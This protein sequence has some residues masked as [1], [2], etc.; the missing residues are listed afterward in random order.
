MST[1]SKASRSSYENLNGMNKRTSKLANTSGDPHTN[2]FA[3]KIKNGKSKPIH[4]ESINGVNLEEQFKAACDAIQ[5]LPKNGPFQPSNEM[6][7]KFY[8]YFKQ[9]TS[10]PIKTSRPSMFKVVERFDLFILI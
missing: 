8:G 6:L 3:T 9:A 2:G 10:G 4:T 5:N 1:I 7:L